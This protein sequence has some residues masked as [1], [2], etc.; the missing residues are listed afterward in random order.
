MPQ[1]L[2]T[3]LV[4]L[5][6]STLAAEV[7]A[8]AITI[9]VTVGISALLAPSRPKP[10]DGQQET[11][12]AVG[13]RYRS[14]GIVH[15]SGQL[16]F[17]ESRN[18]VL[19]KVVTLDTD[20]TSEIIQHRL[21]DNPVNVDGAGTVTNAS[22]R[23][24]VH[25][26]TRLGADDQTAIPELTAAFP[27]WTAD[28]RQ[29]GCSHV[30]LIGDPVKAKY[31]SEVYNNRIPEY[32][33]V[34]KAAKIY[35]PRLDDTAVIGFDAAGDPIMGA[36]PQRLNDK[37][38]WAWS[39]NWAL[40]T[41]DDIAHP[42]AYGCGYE[43]V[44][45]TNIAQEA[46]YCDEPD[47]IYGGGNI[48]RWRAWAR[49]GLTTEERRAVLTSL[50]MAADGFCW[51]DADAKFNLMA[52]RWEEPDVVITDDHIL[53]MTASLGPPAQQRTSA[54]KVLYTE[55]A[56]GYKEQES[57]TIAVPGAADDPNTDP[58]SVQAYYVPHH[59]QAMRVGKLI[60][61]Q[62][63]P[64]RWHI[65]MMLNLY[66]LNLIGK[67]YCRVETNQLGVYAYFK[68]GGLKLHLAE[69]PPRV[70][71]A[72]LDEVRPTDWD[73]DPATEERPPPGGTEAPPPVVTIE[74]PQNVTVAIVGITFEG[75]SGYGL[76][77]TWDAPSRPDLTAQAQY[78][79][80]GAAA[81]TEM[82]VSQDDEQATS[83]AISVDL[84]YEVQVRFVTLTGRVSAWTASG[85]AFAGGITADSSLITIDSSTATIDRS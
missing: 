14:Y 75:A 56:I 42:D 80:I 27:E 58:Q 36:G 74:Q 84:D 41:A 66:G 25:L 81:W 49:Y 18:G 59:N 28:H 22:Y 33:Q 57:N 67:R 69:S 40:V 50:E 26:Y 44:N 35:D 78:R 54:V 70:E 77:V 65:P 46:D 62:L 71:V 60:A 32:S 64:D 73:F 38:T 30:A 85:T 5:G 23:G 4:S 17:L 11:K 24:A 76:K 83:G 51:Q 34:R 39:D 29:R 37:S 31:F 68:I 6:L 3:F 8:T 10:S 1:A 79:A 7:V 19:G 48:A 12:Q 13:T 16:T 21:N 55:A 82:T 9:A 52:G 43:N 53:G 20:E 63:A 47:A 15:S 72:S 2:A 45:W 61:N